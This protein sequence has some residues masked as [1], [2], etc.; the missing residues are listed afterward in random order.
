MLKKSR[1]VQGF[2]ALPDLGLY[3]HESPPLKKS[4]PSKSTAPDPAPDADSQPE[5]SLDGS[6]EDT[7]TPARLFE[8]GASVTLRPLQVGDIGLV[9]Q[10][11]ALMYSN[12]FGWD[13]KQVE[14]ATAGNLIQWHRMSKERKGGI[15]AEVH[16]TFAGCIFHQPGSDNPEV[17]RVRLFMVE[18]WTRG[19]GVG[20][21]LL[22]ASVSAAKAQGYKN[23]SLWTSSQLVSARRMYTRQ[24]WTRVEV[25]P[26]IKFGINM[27]GEVWNYAIA[28]ATEEQSCRASRVSVAADTNLCPD[29]IKINSD[30]DH[31]EDPG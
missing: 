6:N 21:K 5:S 7:S 11:Q 20:T 9:T 26:A 18:T 31:N 27:E 19:Q 24:G 1:W 15:I 23:M 2:A 17:A 12:E 4:T 10:R 3:E 30:E 13:G 25:T 14:V 8:E 29:I 28:H 22:Q 16:G